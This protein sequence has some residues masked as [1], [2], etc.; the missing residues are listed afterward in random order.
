[1]SRTRWLLAGF[2]LLLFWFIAGAVWIPA[3]QDRLG[4]R[5]AELLEG[6]ETGYP[7]VTVRFDGLEAHL[8]GWVRHETESKDIEVRIA[9]QLR[10][11]GL[12]GSGLNPV[13][14]V[15]NRIEI[16]PYPA[17]WLLLTVQGSHA[18]LYGTAATDF[19]ARDVSRLVEERWE[20]AGGRMSTRLQTRPAAFDEARG[21]QSTLDQ[22]P[23]PRSQGGGDSA[24]AWYARIGGSWERLT[25]DASDELLRQRHGQDVVNDS[26]WSSVVQP[27]LS[28]TRRYQ[29]TERARIAEA[30]R[31]A[32]LA[33]P[34][35]FLAVRDQRLLLRGE[36]ASLKI[37]RELLNA[38]ITGLPGWRVLDDLRVNDQ[39]REVAEFAPITTALLPE[40]GEG[41][42]GKSFFLGLSGSAWEPV[43][44]EIGENSRPWKNL[45]PA[46]LPPALLQEDSLMVAQWLQ[47]SAQGIPSLPIP[48]QPSYLTLALLPDKVILAGQL[49][50][51]AHRTRIIE[52]VKRTY[53]SK[54]V[55]FADALL[56]RGTCEPTPDVE[57]TVRS[58]PPLPAAK[59]PPLLAFARPGQ[60]WKAQA[61]TEA[62][63]TPGA[64]A[65]SGLLPPDFPAAM[66]EDTFSAEAYDHIRHHWQSQRAKP[67]A[68]P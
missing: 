66:A 65:P 9:S 34:H 44:W 58:L 22:L 49:A 25:L 61:A 21:I 52:A 4:K 42:P 51:E 31:Q 64:L 2:W 5:A 26:E 12:P 48:A 20:K 35:V 29:Q 11:S 55:L 13:Q 19:E 7:P 36:V 30:E 27:A 50:E 56:A 1:M 59:D 16:A 60:V 63:L 24:Q 53:G 67:A 46:D 17:G 54:V 45:L 14:K 68:K 23:T 62:L 8:E 47:G 15:H 33:P 39:R 3:L 43:D 28:H 41:S 6:V 32:K 37:K 40:S 38:V 18:A 10:L 57:Q